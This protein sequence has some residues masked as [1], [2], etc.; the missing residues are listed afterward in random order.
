MTDTEVQDVS[1]R[2]TDRRSPWPRPAVEP[3]LPPAAATKEEELSQYY[4]DAQRVED[5][6]VDALSEAII[7]KLLRRADA[8]RAVSFALS[9]AV[10]AKNEG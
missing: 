5:A 2:V 4:A 1:S 6:F 7:A 9:G 10:G 8:E 3:V